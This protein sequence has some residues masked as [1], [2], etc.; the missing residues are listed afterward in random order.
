MAE[1]LTTQEI[2]PLNG[3]LFA[4]QPGVAGFPDT[5]LPG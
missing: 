3:G 4:F 2:S 1:A 5:L